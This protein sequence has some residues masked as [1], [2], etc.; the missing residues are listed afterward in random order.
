MK[1][2]AQLKVFSLFPERCLAESGIAFPDS[3]MN[4]FVPTAKNADDFQKLFEA[5]PIVH[6]SK[7]T[8]ATLL[9]LGTEDLRVPMSQGMNFY[10][11]LKAYNKTTE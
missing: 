11:A 1:Y 6:A 5:S 10:R 3:D 2:N 4:T 9:L 7:V 8:A